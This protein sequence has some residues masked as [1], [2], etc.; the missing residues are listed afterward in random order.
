MTSCNAFA[1]SIERFNDPNCDE[2]KRSAHNSYQYEKC[3]SL[4]DPLNGGNVQLK[5]FD[6]ENVDYSLRG[7]NWVTKDN[8]CGSTN[9]SPIDLRWDWEKLNATADE[10]FKHYENLQGNKYTAKLSWKKSKSTI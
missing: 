2:S 9:Q 5:F 4:T 7:A 6:D 1:I 8:E 3:Y 10:Y